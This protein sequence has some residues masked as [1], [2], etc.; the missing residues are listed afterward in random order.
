MDQFHLE[1][2]S[3]VPVLPLDRH[4]V[5]P[6]G[7]SAVIL[8]EKG[9]DESHHLSINERSDQYAPI[10]LRRRQGLTGNPRRAPSVCLDALALTVL[11]DIFQ[12]PDLNSRHVYSMPHIPRWA[13]PQDPQG[14][15]S[16]GAEECDDAP[17][18]NTDKS[19]STWGLAHFLQATSVDDEG[20]IFS[21]VVPQSR[22]LN[23]KSGIRSS[24]CEY[25][26]TLAG[27][28][29]PTREFGWSTAW[30]GRRRCIFCGFFGNAPVK[31]S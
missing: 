26:Q 11:V 24:W 5:G 31:I 17:T 29:S 8:G 20:T 15:G 2:K 23:S 7:Q 6:V 16:N 13:A 4:H 18:A 25:S 21:K 1:A 28:Q 30:G 27:L 10:F 22:H 19:F 9:K 12:Q 3:L 14:P